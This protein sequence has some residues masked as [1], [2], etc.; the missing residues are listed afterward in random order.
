[1]SD[2][3]R[4]LQEW[5]RAVITDPDAE[6][7]PGG[8]VHSS[9]RLS[10][11]RR[12]DLYRRSYHLRLLEAMRAFY[13]GLRHMLGHELFDEFALDY[14][15]AR[16]SRSYTLQRLGDG[17]A[18]H[19][20]ANRPDSGAAAEAWPSLMIDLVRLERTF[21]EVYDARGTERDRLPG[22]GDLPAAPDAGWLATTITPASCLRLVSSSFPAG[23]YLSAVRRGEEPPL[24]VP[25]VSYLAVNRRDYAVTL[26]PLEAPEYELLEALVGGDPIEVAASVAAVEADAAWRLVRGWA[27]RGFFL[28][29]HP[30]RLEEHVTA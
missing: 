10:A 23:P 30:A 9:S 7:A 21:A 28:A 16:P 20:E 22:S 11:A 29:L 19:L 24:P 4:R 15:R 25:A 27:D 2:D 8:V 18:D 12:L 1:V 6:I 5:L 26:T 17:F 13:P 3:L 14:I